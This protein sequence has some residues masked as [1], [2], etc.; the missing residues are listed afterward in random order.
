[1]SE[2]NKSLRIRTTVGETNP[3]VVNVQLTQDYDV[4]EI[5]SIKLKQEDTYKLHNANY[6]VIVGRVLA[7]NGFGVPNAKISVFIEGDFDDST[8]DGISSIY[9]YSS[10]RS[11]DGDGVRYN[12]LPDNK[13]DDC[14]Q[15][16]GTFPNKSYLLDN[17]ILIEVFDKYYKYTTRTNNSGDYIL[18]G[19]P[20]GS[21]TIHMDLD[22][23]DCGILSQR[24]RD[25]VYKGY[26]IEQFENP[27]QFK[28]G[29]DLSSLSQIFTQDQVVNVVP[30]W[31]NDSL[32]E[33]IG[34]TRAD[35]NIS[36]KFEPTCV[37]MGCI[38]GDNA[39]NGISKKCVPTNQMGAMDELTTG[40]GTIEMIRKTVGGD[41]EE[42]Q[43]KGTQLIDGN[44]VWCYQI[45]M[46][47]DYMMTDEYGNMVPTDDP[48]KGIPTRTRV[49]FRVSMQDMEGNTDNYF[50]AKV[51]VPHNPQD[52]LGQDA[53]HEEYDYEF[54]S[55]TREDSFRD[56]FWNNVY[57]VKSYIPR[58]QKSKTSKSE[59]FSGIKHCN[60]YGQNNPMPYN[61]I[62][63]RLPFMFSLL[64]VLIK[65][66]IRI[67]GI[68]NS[69]VSALG[70]ALADLGNTG[71]EVPPW[72]VKLL[73]I[74]KGDWVSWY[75][76]RGLY[77][78]ATGW[79][80]TVLQEGLCP[81]LDN[82]YFAP[83]SP[84]NLWKPCEHGQDPP[85]KKGKK[86]ECYD[87]L[88]QTLNFIIGKGED[89]DKD[90]NKQKIET[91]IDSTS[92]DEQ[93]SSDDVDVACLTVKTDYL[94]SCI[95]MNLAQE[96]KVINFDFY[97]DWVNGVIYMPRWMRI[98][99]K[100]RTYLFGLFTSKAKIKACMDN[101][102]FQTRRYTQQ[103]AL[104]YKIESGQKAFTKIETA[105]GC[106][107]NKKKQK[108]HTKKGKK[109]YKIFG[110]GD[111][112][113]GKAGNGGIVHEDQTSRGEYVYY[114]KPCEWK[115]ADNK[116]VTLFANDIVLLGSLNDCSLYGIPQAF[117]HLTSSSYIMPTNL[118]LTNMDDDGQLYADE[119][120]TICSTTSSSETATLSEVEKSFSGT[121]NYY[122]GSTEE[123]V[124]Y[125][126]GGDE[127][128]GLN[129]DDV[130][131]VTEAAGIA[132]NYSGPQQ[133]KKNFSKLYQ[134]GGH[135]LGLSCT[136]S[137]TNIKS[138]INL[139]RICE[140][141]SSMSQRREE[142]S[143]V[144]KS[145]DGKSLTM[146]YKYFVP[147]GLISQD[148]IVDGDFR[149]MFATMN[150]NRLLCTGGTFDENTGYPIYDFRYLRP[151][152]FNGSLY[153]KIKNS[154]NYNK[155]LTSAE[156]K[157]EFYLWMKNS[158]VTASDDYDENETANTYRRTVES[159]NNDYYMFR[160]G[161]SSL[162]PIEQ[163]KRYLLSD[164]TA[165]LP[166]YENSF[167][168][169]FGLKDGATALDEF[170][171]QFFST[172]ETESIVVSSPSIDVNYEIDSCTLQAGS[173]I[174]NTRNLTE[175]INYSAKNAI[176]GEDVNLKENEGV[177]WVWNS[178]DKKIVIPFGSYEFTAKDANES[179]VS[180]T[181]VIGD[182]VLAYG[183]EVYDFEFRTKGLAEDDI[184]SSGFNLNSGYVRIPNSYAINNEDPIS[185]YGGNGG[186]LI[187]ESESLAYAVIGNKSKNIRGVTLG[188]EK[189]KVK[190]DGDYT[191]VYLW[192]PGATYDIYLTHLCEGVLY[193]AYYTSFNISGV[194]E[195]DLYLG[196]KFL[197]YSEKLSKL[198]G[199]WWTQIDGPSLEDWA[200][201]HYLFRQ[202]DDDME[203]F[204]NQVFGLD[205]SNK[206]LP[207]V[208]FGQPERVVTNDDGVTM[209]VTDDVFY[210]ANG[211]YFDGY[212]LS[213]ESIVP[214]WRA[215][216]DAGTVRKKQFGE[217]VIYKDMPASN[218]CC[219]AKITGV[220]ENIDN[221]S[222]K[223]RFTIARVSGTLDKLTENQ[224][225][226][227]KVNNSR[228]I[229]PIFGGGDSFIVYDEDVEVGDTI[230]V[231]PIFVYPV[232]Y[233]P[234]YTHG[235]FIDWYTDHLEMGVSISD[236]S[237]E[238]APELISFQ[239]FAGE[240]ET[241]NGVTYDNAF[242]SG[243]TIG[244]K[245]FKVTPKR[246]NDI[247]DSKSGTNLTIASAFTYY[248]YSKTAKKNLW[249]DGEI[250]FE[251]IEGRPSS[252]GGKED[253]LNT[254]NALT[255]ANNA[256]ELDT[257]TLVTEIYYKTNGTSVMFVTT[258]KEVYNSGA[259][260]YYLEGECPLKSTG[261]VICDITS[262]E[263]IA[264][265][266]G[267]RIFFNMVAY[268]YC[269][270]NNNITNLSSLNKDKVNEKIVVE[271]YMFSV[272]AL[273]CEWVAKF[274]AYQTENAEDGETNVIIY[275]TF[276]DDD[277][278]YDD[279]IKGMYDAFVEKG[280]TPM[281]EY[282]YDTAFT[283]TDLDKIIN[284]EDKRT[285]KIKNRGFAL[286][287][288]DT[289]N[290]LGVDDEGRIPDNR[291]IVG[292]LTGESGTRGSITDM[293]VYIPK[294][295]G[296]YNALA[297]DP[298][299]EFIPITSKVYNPSMYPSTGG[300][301]DWKIKSNIEWEYTFSVLG[302]TN[303][304]YT[305]VN[306]LSFVDEG[307]NETPIPYRTVT[308]GSGGQTKIVRA[309]SIDSEDMP[310]GYTLPADLFKA[311]TDT[312]GD[313]VRT[314]YGIP[315]VKCLEGIDSGT[316]GIFIMVKGK[317]TKQMTVSDTEVDE[318]GNPKQVPYSAM[319]IFVIS[320]KEKK[321]YINHKNGLKQYS[322]LG[323]GGGQPAITVT[324][325]T[326]C[327]WM[328]TIPTGND[329]MHFASRAGD[330]PT[331]EDGN[332]KAI[333]GKG[334]T[335]IFLISDKTPD[336]KEKDPRSAT[337]IIQIVK[338]DNNGS[339]VKDGAG[340]IATVTE[341][342]FKET[343]GKYHTLY[344]IQNAG[345][346]IP[347][348]GGGDSG[349]D[350][351]DDTGGGTGTYT[352][353]PF[354]W[355]DGYDVTDNN[356]INT[357][358]FRKYI[359]YPTFSK[360]DKVKIFNF[361][362][363]IIDEFKGPS[364]NNDASLE[365]TWYLDGPDST[366]IAKVTDS[367]SVG[368]E[369]R[370]IKMTTGNFSGQSGE[371]YLELM[372]KVYAGT[373]GNG[374]FRFDYK[375]HIDAATWGYEYE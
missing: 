356:P 303:T 159:T 316:C 216:G 158:G 73:G 373:Q 326:D 192:K 188:K 257:S 9:P 130:V 245:N 67:V 112:K 120:G 203:Y 323:N 306:W 81:D 136:N 322:Y 296:Q 352:T 44:G 350:G 113:S 57:T 190:K 184:M 48:D 50:R 370:S 125:G 213:N 304:A 156:T 225:C 349:G 328:V 287:G 58:F 339:I 354:I 293:R 182:G 220:T 277:K 327:I 183:K 318:E 279:V 291:Y 24:P 165:S 218:K 299:L 233:R 53:G 234:F 264:Q 313:T 134:P 212:D 223:N 286:D 77:S 346:I 63:I 342:W 144:E 154:E 199:T 175:P 240:T 7:N 308:T 72:N 117:K 361:P 37:F 272:R 29:T 135:F 162:D 195:I 231:Y 62:R 268:A 46:N 111:K 137:E 248:D 55:L 65:C 198:S 60:I 368:D 18:C 140:V 141:G 95:E 290:D 106:H 96:Y 150:Q 232:M 249:E 364:A 197:P 235:R 365:F 169:Y 167:Y 155:H 256:A 259:T 332:I 105:N 127:D 241:H 98:V 19:V 351:G 34:I 343:D 88:N 25:F 76:F 80:L 305:K 227:C 179:E 275:G 168:F 157:D 340:N 282:F 3:S 341:D 160:L 319:T 41:I 102:Y 219:D 250:S 367:V 254:P 148:E 273:F 267:N 170:T 193:T 89:I 42:F 69:V 15:I 374:Y 285:A 74:H 262:Y 128:N 209:E 251:I 27:N 186:V 131:A 174:V 118:A 363:I 52:Y 61:N 13:V 269:I 276:S 164:T 320:G 278:G 91:S 185:I 12:L 84:Q 333:T 315:S 334:N 284:E 200:M 314:D 238:Y 99:K 191:N 196:S 43:V 371:W 40:E 335:E 82:W 26:T 252:F 85:R 10:T 20:T 90:G 152:G 280:V 271:L 310:S 237:S 207:T 202:T 97:N 47:L 115:I 22:L 360:L 180:K 129:Y 258:D 21:Q 11:T 292:L 166:Q 143:K 132:W 121:Q 32:G 116:R 337:T 146:T 311:D 39:S 49:R 253:L 124:V 100:K 246:V 6:G 239:G 101:T 36:F 70:N 142:I 45:P 242:Y 194:D 133:G 325:N 261:Y 312:D 329:W 362:E 236:V 270:I 204:T 31:G 230:S 178:E 119:S 244:G 83:M 54:G 59:R 66:Y 358:V 260:Y 107:S 359:A 181:I 14:H 265:I 372:V 189:T 229:Y 87:I 30:F 247:T 38:V 94:I 211:D 208:L 224:G 369:R 294:Y 324:S 255:Y 122:S 171:K 139:Q 153:S 214:T 297:T 79:R 222:G 4:F 5:M 281:K 300:D 274:A 221:V 298:T 201:R 366:Q 215:N 1:M 177:S 288:A 243:S 51:L 283:P 295:L 114:F 151:N 68:I 309:K 173:I 289:L 110:S 307:G 71:I 8:V 123:D 33:T 355:T 109:H 35:I 17:D 217:M 302:T 330:Y 108:C 104:E 301:M 228:H 357:T 353:E 64:C 78:V 331:D 210:S 336:G 92:I 163:K 172:C 138:C 375:F 345:D 348:D 161:L 28:T 266:A 149:S 226:I 23:S 126:T 86:F 321:L 16:V 176:T 344:F 2:T 338:T 347:D 206:V 93:N 56:L 263:S 205:G 75:P 103:C 147:T 187:V 317:S 145:P